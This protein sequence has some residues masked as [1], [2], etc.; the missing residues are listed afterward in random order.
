MMDGALVQLQHHLQ[1]Q[2][3]KAQLLFQVMDGVAQPHPAMTIGEQ[4]EIPEVLARRM[5]TGKKYHCK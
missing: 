4:P 2:L 3:P 1:S 5:T